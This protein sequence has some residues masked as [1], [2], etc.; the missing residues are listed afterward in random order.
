[1][2]VC[3]KNRTLALMLHPMFR[4]ADAITCMTQKTPNMFD[5]LFLCSPS[6][7]HHMTENIKLVMCSG[8]FIYEGTAVTS[9]KKLK[10]LQFVSQHFQTHTLHRVVKALPTG[11]NHRSDC[12]DKAECTSACGSLL[13]RKFRNVK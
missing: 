10:T 8:V 9:Q 4:G 6:L 3:L 12:C 2:T 13:K 7:H 5:T 11:G 1:M